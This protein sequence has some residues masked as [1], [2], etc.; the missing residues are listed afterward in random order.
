MFI[1]LM[2]IYVLWQF[3]N[4]KLIKGAVFTVI[5]VV[6]LLLVL[7]MDNS[8]VATV[9]NRLTSAQ[10]LSDLTTSRSDVYALYI[11]EITD[12]WLTFLFGKGMAA[13]A[14]YRDPHNIYLEIFYYVGLIGLILI[15]ALYF[16]AFRSASRMTADAPKQHFLAKYSALAVCLITYF[17][18]QG[19]F[20]QVFHG[21]M[22][23]VALSFMLAPQNLERMD[24]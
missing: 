23:L 16:S 14:L 11:G 5:A 9:L 2:G 6:A 20:M 21:E 3:L 24:A 18:L 8:P 15:I 10:S 17:V 13:D 7:S 12:N 4:K 19:I 1:F 22:F